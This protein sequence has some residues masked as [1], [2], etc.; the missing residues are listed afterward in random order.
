MGGWRCT[1]GLGPDCTVGPRSGEIAL[2]LVALL[3]KAASSST[4]AVRMV[5]GRSARIL[6]GCG[7]GDIAR[8]YLFIFVWGGGGENANGRSPASLW[9]SPLWPPLSRNR[10]RTCLALAFRLWRTRVAESSRWVE[11]FQERGFLLLSWSAGPVFGRF[12]CIHV[13]IYISIQMII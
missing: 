5:S 2:S 13:Y 4:P 6:G 12:K 7:A 1:T 3:Y 9:A 10:R 11:S 8:A